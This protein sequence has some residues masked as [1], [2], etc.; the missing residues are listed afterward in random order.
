MVQVE[1]D[2]LTITPHG[3]QR[4]PHGL[5]QVAQ[6]Q[7]KQALDEAPWRKPTARSRQMDVPRARSALYP[8]YGKDVRRCWLKAGRAG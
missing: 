4:S 3:E 1:Q 2:M 8:R 7:L 5:S 6:T